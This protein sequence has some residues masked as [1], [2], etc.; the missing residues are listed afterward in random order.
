MKMYSGL[1]EV[2]VEVALKL[3]GTQRAQEVEVEV[4]L[5]LVQVVVAA[6]EVVVYPVPTLLN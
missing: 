6:P 1:E 5:R 2:V 3:C 4:S